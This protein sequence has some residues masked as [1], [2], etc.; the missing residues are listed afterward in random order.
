MPFSTTLSEEL[1]D[2]TRPLSVALSERRYVT[3]RPSQTV[4]VDFCVKVVPIPDTH[5]AVELY[6]FDAAG[7]RPLPSVRPRCAVVSP[8]A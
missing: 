2:G 6:L 7:T 4:G 8:C 3:T 1:R 5:I